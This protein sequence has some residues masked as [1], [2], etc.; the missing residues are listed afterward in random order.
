LGRV[1]YPRYWWVSEEGASMGKRRKEWKELF[2]G[3]QK[4]LHKETE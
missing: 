2:K 1:T 3:R 4:A